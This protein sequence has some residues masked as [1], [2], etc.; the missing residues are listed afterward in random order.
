MIES[1]R[2]Y[3]ASSVSADSRSRTEK[4]Q[5]P[6]IRPARALGLCRLLLPSAWPF[7]ECPSMTERPLPTPAPGAPAPSTP[8]GLDWPELPARRGPLFL[9][10]IFQDPCPTLNGTRCVTTPQVQTRRRRPITLLVW[11]G[12]RYLQPPKVALVVLTQEAEAHTLTAR[13]H[14]HSCWVQFMLSHCK[15]RLV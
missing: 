11:R 13:S 7:P 15:H 12:D 10:R 2:C 3:I 1:R 6:N 9:E 14:S 8:L 5:R 4:G